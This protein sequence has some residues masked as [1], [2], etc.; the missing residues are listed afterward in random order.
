MHAR[1]QLPKLAII[2]LML[3]VAGAAFA[4][5]SVARKTKMSCAT[6]H[7]NA[8]G[9]ADL[10]DAGK[11]FKADNA[12]VPAASAEGATYVGSQKCRMCH[13]AQHEAWGTTKHAKAFEALVSGDKAIMDAQAKALGVTLSGSAAT[14][15]AC[16]AC[17]ATGAG[18]GGYPPSDTTKTASYAAVGCEMCHG[19]GSKHVAAPKEEKKNF[20]AVTK[21]D[22]MCKDCHTAAMSPKFNFDEYKKNGVHVVPA[23]TDAPAK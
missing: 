23:A 20:I 5:P 6:C 1:H 18:L 22:A 3:C 13:K 7:S 4:F 8:S 2:V 12:K 15:D 17:H 9:G 14:N 16:L 19:P 21:T 10:T 11:A